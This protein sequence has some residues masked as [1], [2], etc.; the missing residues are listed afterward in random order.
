[1]TE[2]F[3][4]KLF[5]V[6]VSISI[7]LLLIA[8]VKNISS[9]PPKSFRIYY[10]KINPTILK[11]ML[12]YDINIVEASFFNSKDVEF[13]HESSSKVVG[14]LS[15]V[16][17]GYWD[18]LLVNDLRDDDYLRNE[19]NEKLQNLSQTNYLGDLSSSHFRKILFKHLESRI[20]EKK[21]DGACVWQLKVKKGSVIACSTSI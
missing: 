18:T 13:I 6:F 21:M 7:S 4:F 2:K 3:F 17:I 10:D 8:F 12:N 14:Y 1:M 9:K 5:L 19:S 15:L 16:E 11:E 20:L